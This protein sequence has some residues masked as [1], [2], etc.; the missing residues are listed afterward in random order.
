MTGRGLIRRLPARPEDRAA[1]DRRTYRATRAHLT[2][3]SIPGA[4]TR[5]RVEITV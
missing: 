5:L 4:G 3:E 2:I 1:G